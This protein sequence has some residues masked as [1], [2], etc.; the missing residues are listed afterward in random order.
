MNTDEKIT[1]DTPEEI[2]LEETPVEDILPGDSSSEEINEETA[3]DTSGEMPEEAEEKQPKVRKKMLI[4]YVLEVLRKYSAPERKISYDEI[5]Y[6]VK[7]DFDMDCDKKAV[8]RN[9]RLLMEHGYKIFKSPEGFYMNEKIFTPEEAFMLW[10]GLM[11][12][13]YIS[14]E[15]ITSLTNK[16]SS[17]CGTAYSFGSKFYG[18]VVSTHVYPEDFVHANIMSLLTEMAGNKKVSFVYNQYNN[19]KIITPVTDK[20]TVSPYAVVNIDNEYYLAAKE[21]EE[22][23][24][25]MS[26]FKISMISSLESTSLPADDIKTVN[27]YQKGFDVNVFANE[28]ISP[29]RG[30]KLICHVNVTTENIPDVTDTFGDTFRIIDEEDGKSLIEV[31]TNEERMYKWAVANADIAEVIFPQMLRFKIKDYFDVNSWKYR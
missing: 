2:T 15:E 16:L 28:F 20:I 18:G 27:G 30:E 24:G 6:F 23:K 4:L 5:I 9:I 12:S 13:K 25:S 31:T 26:C 21:D 1:I 3:D 19:E 7:T 22:K 11:S 8:T 29:F 10:E 14:K 17:F